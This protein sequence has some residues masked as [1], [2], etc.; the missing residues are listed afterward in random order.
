MLLTWDALVK[1]HTEGPIEP[2]CAIFCR[3]GRRSEV[4]S[5]MTDGRRGSRDS[6]A[7]PRPAMST[8]RFAVI[9]RPSKGPATTIA[10]GDEK[11]SND[12]GYPRAASSYILY[13]PDER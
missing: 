8:A 6:Q 13:L 5:K 12:Y 1:R 4:N 9:L 10:D 11:G 3:L 2:L 7:Q